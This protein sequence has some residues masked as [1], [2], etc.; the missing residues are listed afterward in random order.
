MNFGRRRPIDALSCLVHVHKYNARS[1][2]PALTR[3]DAAAFCL[4]MA[5]RRLPYCALLPPSLLKQLSRS[6]VLRCQRAT[7]NFKHPHVG[8]VLMSRSRWLLVLHTHTKQMHASAW[9]NIT[10]TASKARTRRRLFVRP[11]L[12]PPSPCISPP[13]LPKP[14]LTAPPTP[15]THTH[16]CHTDTSTTHLPI[17]PT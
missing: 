16:T 7:S 1:L 9:S 10:R 17:N 8:V 5:H 3:N 12:I 13:C 6:S 11:S 4:S 2:L 15:H 14:T